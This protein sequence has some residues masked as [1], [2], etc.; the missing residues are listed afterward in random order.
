MVGQSDRA[1][2]DAAAWNEA[3]ARE[4]VIRELASVEQFSPSEVMRA[5][6]QL[7]VKRA[8]LYQLIKAYRERPVTSSLLGRRTGPPRGVRLLPEE[9]E[10][11]IEEALRDFYKSRQILAHPDW[12]AAAALPE[13]RRSR[14][15][16]RLMDAAL[17]SRLSNLSAQLE[18][19]Q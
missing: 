5:C 15:L 17:A 11:V 8:R 1:T 4:A 19:V 6:R 7:G 16:A 9:V 18:A 12:T 3:V 2:V 10:A 13:N 14:V